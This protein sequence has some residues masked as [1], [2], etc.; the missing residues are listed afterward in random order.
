MSNLSKDNFFNFL[1]QALGTSL[2]VQW[3]RICLP[4]WRYRFDPW[5]GKIS[6][7]TEQLSLCTTPE[8]HVPKAC[9]PQQ[10]K[11]QQ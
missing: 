6:R 2:V 5:S 4:C 9:D 11:P 10:E 3:L 1:K 8:A 7:A